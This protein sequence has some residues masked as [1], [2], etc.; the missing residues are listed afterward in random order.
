M[1]KTFALEKL[2]LCMGIIRSYC[3]QVLEFRYEG[4]GSLANSLSS[5][6]SA[7]TAS[8][9]WE[10]EFRALGP[11]SVKNQKQNQTEYL[12][13]DV[14]SDFLCLMF[15]FVSPDSTGFAK[16]FII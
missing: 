7:S 15:I 10:K 5:L 6:G 8:I 4:S 3:V 9:S 13:Y 12:N 2:S 14:D 11:R 16:L 1:G